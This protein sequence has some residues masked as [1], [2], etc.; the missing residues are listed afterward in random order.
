MATVFRSWKA[1]TAQR[2]NRL[3]ERNGPFWQREWFDRWMRSEVEAEK[4]LNYIRENPV[5][6]GLVSK[7]QDYVW[8]R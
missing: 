7:W 4:V 2:C 5:K 1:Q 8:C 3:L 6:A